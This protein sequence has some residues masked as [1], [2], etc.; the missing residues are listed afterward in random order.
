MSSH[1]ESQIYRERWKERHSVDVVLVLEEVFRFYT[2][3]TA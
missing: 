3:A 2:L 1:L